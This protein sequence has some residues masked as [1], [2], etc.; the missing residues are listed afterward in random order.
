M[1]AAPAAAETAFVAE[2]AELFEAASALP[3]AI[4]QVSVAAKLNVQE[5]GAQSDKVVLSG[6]TRPGAERVL[7]AYP[8][9]Q[10]LVARLSPEAAERLRLQESMTDPETGIAWNLMQ[11]DGWIAADSLVPSLDPIWDAAWELFADRCTACHE[12][13]VP[14]NYTANQWRS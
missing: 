10:I 2:P 4:A 13:R 7:F 8:G 12:R 6:W 5:H 1:S 9:K 11:I 14:S 3:P